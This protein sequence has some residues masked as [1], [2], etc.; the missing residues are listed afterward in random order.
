MRFAPVRVVVGVA[1]ALVA[2]SNF[3]SGGIA[4]ATFD[5]AAVEVV[6]A[7]PL[8]ADALVA[9]CPGPLCEC[10]N[11]DTCAS[12]CEDDDCTMRCAH[13]G[14]CSNQC[15]DDCASSCASS[16]A[17]NLGCGDDCAAQCESVGSC[18]VVCGRDC[19]VECRDTSSCAVTMI[20]G[21]VKCQRTTACTAICR[22]AGGVRRP[23]RRGVDGSLFCDATVD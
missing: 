13:A 17:C 18:A 7:A 14:T 22:D 16:G 3:D 4:V 9:P 15:G 20:D 5:A 8:R 23:A 21:V 10:E 19:V 2:A 6:D 12:R 1:A 11:A